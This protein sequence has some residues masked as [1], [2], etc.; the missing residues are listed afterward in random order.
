MT[1][2]KAIKILSP[3]KNSY[4]GDAHY[5]GVISVSEIIE[6]L[7]AQP[8]RTG[9]WIE[10]DDEMFVMC[11]ECSKSVRQKKGNNDG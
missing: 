11:S 3:Y 4:F 1:R 10:D 6:L 5:G 9:H 8:Q 2:E 7:S